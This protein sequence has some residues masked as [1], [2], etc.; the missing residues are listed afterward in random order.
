MLHPVPRPPRDRRLCLADANSGEGAAAGAA[1]CDVTWPPGPRM[2]SSPTCAGPRWY[3]GSRSATAGQHVCSQSIT[4]NCRKEAR[5]R[6]SHR[7]T[8]RAQLRAPNAVQS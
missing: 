8:M 7:L 3:S 4:Q 2:H 5:S 6:F 1:G